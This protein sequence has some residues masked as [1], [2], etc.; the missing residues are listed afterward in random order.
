MR[1]KTR[2]RIRTMEPAVSLPFKQTIASLSNSD[3]QL[4][5]S[6]LVYL[7]NLN[8]AEMALFG[9]AWAAIGDKHRRQIIQRLGELAEDNFELN[10]DSV[11]RYCLRDEDSEVRCKAIEGLWENEETSLI[12]PLIDLL[13]QD[14][15]EMVRATAAAALGKFTI[16]AELNKLRSCHASRISHALLAVLSD[17]KK[18]LAV[19]R[20]ALE[21]VAP[22]SLPG[23]TTAIM[24]AY[25]HGDPELRASAI[26]AMGRNSN[27]SWLPVLLEELGNA[28][29]EIR[30]E[31]AGACGELGQE[32]AT[33]YLIKLTRDPDNS[34]QLVAIQALGKIGG[35]A[36]K[37]HLEQCLRHSSEAV[38]DAA[39][40][41]LDE[42]EAGEDPLSMDRIV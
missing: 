21:A 24:D 22:L 39:E 13:E 23:V 40:Q 12:T 7:V 28:D 27:P 31:A 20:R 37:E 34:V 1:R 16:L 35:K 6:S 42:L 3:R 19:R 18:P 2:G 14:S 32:E 25:Y 11:F 17:K 36:A 41:A 38:S 15:S 8:P 5:S 33:P 30:Y 26:H 29:D 10:F 9:Q 4:S